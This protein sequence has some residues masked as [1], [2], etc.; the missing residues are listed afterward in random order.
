MAARHFISMH[1]RQQQQL[2]LSVK[3]RWKNQHRIWQVPGRL[4]QEESMLKSEDY[5]AL[6]AFEAV[7]AAEQAAM[8]RRPGEDV[9]FIGAEL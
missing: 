3:S 2:K 5:A 6:R 1:A 4:A 7:F 8:F 9:V